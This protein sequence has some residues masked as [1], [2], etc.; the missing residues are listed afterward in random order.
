MAEFGEKLKKTLLHPW[1]AFA[2]AGVAAFAASFGTENFVQYS[3][4]LLKLGA[5]AYP[6]Y[7]LVSTPIKAIGKAFKFK[8]VDFGQMTPIRIV[9]DFVASIGATFVGAKAAVS[10]SDTSVTTSVLSPKNAEV[11][12]NFMDGGVFMDI[13]NAPMNVVRGVVSLPDRLIS[14][15]TDNPAFSFFMDNVAPPTPGSALQKALDY[16]TGPNAMGILS[17][18]MTTTAVGLG[19]L[20]VR[21]ASEMTLG[22]TPGRAL[23][24]GLSLLA[25]KAKEFKNSRSAARSASAEERRVTGEEEGTGA[26]H[27]PSASRRPT[28]A[29]EADNSD[30][31]YVPLN[32]TRDAWRRDAMAT[33]VSNQRQTA[34]LH[35]QAD[36][37]NTSAENLKNQAKA[38]FEEIF[39]R[40]EQA[41]PPSSGSKPKPSTGR[42]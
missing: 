32:A 11:L 39:A 15:V 16:T 31:G 36:R 17:A 24:K 13:V 33:I 7:L 28:A 14:Y 8:T 22:T 10:L 3:G 20:A 6:S 23:L 35:A 5:V 2:A 40:Y 25:S 29:S 1:T 12:S 34:A 26:V 21:K 38:S 4:Q 27:T 19:Y 18:A 9:R 30:S 42:S 41:I 37:D